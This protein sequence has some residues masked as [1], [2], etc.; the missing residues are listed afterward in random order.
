MFIIVIKDFI[1]ISLKINCIIY[2][3]V[4]IVHKSAE[5]ISQFYKE[6]IIKTFFSVLI[7]E[8]KCFTVEILSG[9]VFE[10]LCGI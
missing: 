7:E 3:A 9:G 6:C 8:S 10:S 5:K 2:H 1:E 4:L